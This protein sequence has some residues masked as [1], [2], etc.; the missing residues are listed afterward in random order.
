MAQIN[1]DSRT[2]APSAGFDPLPKG[3]YNTIITDEELRPT[4]SNNG[5]FLKVE[6]TVAD[7]QY[8]GRKL[9]TNLNVNNPSQKA[10]E[11]A[12]QNLSAICHCVGIV[13]LGDSSELR[14]RPIKVRV[15]I[16]TEDDD[17]E[18][19]DQN[20]ITGYDNINAVK[21]A[22]KAA[23]GTPIPGTAAS[24]AFQPPPLATAPPPPLAPP[25]VAVQPVY[26]MAPGEQF[27]K[28]QMNGAGWSDQQLIAAGKLIAQAPVTPVAPPPAPM[29]PPPPSQPG[30]PFGGAPPQQP[31]AATA[32][33]QPGAPPPQGAPAAPAAPPPPG[34]AVPQAAPP[35]WGP[36]T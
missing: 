12:L 21:A 28:E 34:V 9:Y 31:W 17:S 6:F 16:R 23:G 14:N 19:D 11:I 10:V 15:K 3:W 18:Y 1:F 22:P 29:A 30:L 4:K 33:P 26:V 5:S 2:V 7:G 27:T 36:Q 20:V 32:P 24:P 35:P 25:P 8:Q 13:V